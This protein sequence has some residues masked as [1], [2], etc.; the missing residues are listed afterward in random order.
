MK[1]LFANLN[2]TISDGSSVCLVGRDGAGKSTLVD[3][4]P[5][6][7]DPL[8]GDIYLDGINLKNIDI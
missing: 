7:Y 5:R 1:K 8:E 2:W 4:I 6:F 3:L